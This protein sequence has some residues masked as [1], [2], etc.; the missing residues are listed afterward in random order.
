MRSVWR[1]AFAAFMIGAAMPVI[2]IWTTAPLLSA[3]EN[4]HF[5]YLTNI[6]LTLVL[7]SL[8][9]FTSTVVLCYALEKRIEQLER[10]LRT[11]RESPLPH[12]PPTSIQQRPL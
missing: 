6:N 9:P 5:I 8:M 4:S 2:T 12:P 1:I 11:W 3:S 10:E 7:A